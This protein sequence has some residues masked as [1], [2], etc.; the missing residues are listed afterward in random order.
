MKAG[1]RAT[2]SHTMGAKVCRPQESQKEAPRQPPRERPC[3][4]W[5]SEPGLQTERAGSCCP[6]PPSLGSLLREP[7]DTG[8]V[9]GPDQ[10][11]TSTVRTAPAGGPEG[12]Q[13]TAHCTRPACCC[14]GRREEEKGL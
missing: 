9:L 6:K 11:A 3:P 12:P 1:T 14:P 5:T 7:Q 10:P 13:N 2:Q 8:P 4:T